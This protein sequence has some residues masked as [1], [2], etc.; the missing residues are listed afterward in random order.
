MLLVPKKTEEHVALTIEYS[1]LIDFDPTLAYTLLNFPRLLL[2]IFDE[3]IVEAQQLLHSH[4]HIQTKHGT[5]GTVKT[6]CHARI[7]SLPPF[8]DTSKKSVGD[9]RAHEF[10]KMIQVAGTV[11]RTGAVRVLE[12]S[13]EYQCMKKNCGFRF[14][15]FAD[16]EQNNMLPTPRSCP[17]AGEAD[18]NGGVKK[19]SSTILN[20]VAGSRV[21]VDYQE[22]RIQDKVK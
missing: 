16:P 15:V 1:D 21:C 18:E 19:C 2:P 9:I 8:E 4:H 17:A 6:H 3:A 5:R 12:V 13:K 14:R 7:I 11:V 20:E 10:E 22:I